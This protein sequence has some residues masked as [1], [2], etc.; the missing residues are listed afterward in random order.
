MVRFGPEQARQ[1]LRSGGVLNQPE[2]RIELITLYL[3]NKST[4]SCAIQATPAGATTTET[5]QPVEHRLWL[6]CGRGEKSRGTP[7]RADYNNF[8]IFIRK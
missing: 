1:L 2:M 8:G 4:A 6:V 5:L 7:I 3:Q